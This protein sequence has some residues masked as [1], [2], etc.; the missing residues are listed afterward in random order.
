MGAYI[1]YLM[2]LFDKDVVIKIV[3]TVLSSNVIYL[4]LI[5]TES[6]GSLLQER[7]VYAV[8]ESGQRCS[9]C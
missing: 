4:D 1:R 8:V 2:S 7:P 3:D 9:A 5:F 6:K